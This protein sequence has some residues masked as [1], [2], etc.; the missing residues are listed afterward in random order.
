MPL[1]YI[2]DSAYGVL[3]SYPL[4]TLENETHLRNKMGLSIEPIS[5]TYRKKDGY[6][7]KSFFKKM[8]KLNYNEFVREQ[9]N[10]IVDS[11]SHSLAMK[12]IKEYLE[13]LQIPCRGS[14]YFETVH[15]LCSKRIPMGQNLTAVG[16]DILPYLE[17]HGVDTL[18]PVVDEEGF[19][20]RWNEPN[21]QEYDT[22]D[23]TPEVL[24]KGFKVV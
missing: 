22:R 23:V 17:L 21:H 15:E 5:P 6:V 12:S 16:N 1:M 19:Q 11:D 24:G 14:V 20:L 8:D 18:P 4:L 9:L 2:Q 7:K 10:S 3:I 13:N